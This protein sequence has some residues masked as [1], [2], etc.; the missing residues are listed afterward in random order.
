MRK[1]TSVGMRLSSDSENTRN[2]FLKFLFIE[3]TLNEVSNAH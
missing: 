2:A 1:G 3:L